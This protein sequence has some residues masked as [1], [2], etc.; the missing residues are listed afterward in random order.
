[1]KEP[2]PVQTEEGELAFEVDRIRDVRFVGRRVCRRKEEVGPWKREF[3]VRWVGYGAADDSWE[4]EA[5]FIDDEPIRTFEAKRPCLRPVDDSVWRRTQRVGESHQATLP[6]WQPLPKPPPPSTPPPTPPVVWVASPPP[7][8][9]AVPEAAAAS[10]P[11]SAAKARSKGR[12]N[13]KARA[14]DRPMARAATARAAAAA[15][16]A[17]SADAAVG[18]AAVTA[19]TV[20]VRRARM[21]ATSAALARAKAAA[22]VVE[23][24]CG[25]GGDDDGAAGGG[26]RAE[27]RVD[28]QVMMGEHAEQTAALLT[29][30]AFGPYSPL[31]FVG[32]TDC[33]LGLFA[34][35]DLPAG[36]PICE[37]AGPIL[38]G[39]YQQQSGYNLGIPGGEGGVGA[40]EDRFFIDG[41]SD[42]G[43]PGVWVSQGCG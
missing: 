14:S 38:P 16:T 13:A 27:V 3:L 39:R 30:A 5:S 42:Q 11:S 18:G 29:A 8:P 15:A 26:R 2:P 34:R 12:A 25:E 19:S 20:G 6:A 23:G 4:P 36:S 28:C 41:A 31:C 37:Y 43:E 1:M 35:V 9:A 21:H 24:A 32:P 17:A 7:A 10:L 22:T 40:I 33:D